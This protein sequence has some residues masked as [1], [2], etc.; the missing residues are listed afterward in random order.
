MKGAYSKFLCEIEVAKMEARLRQ[1][2]SSPLASN[3][4]S[5]AQSNRND[6]MK[7]DQCSDANHIIF[8]TMSRKH[9]RGAFEESEHPSVLETRP[10][11]VSRRSNT[12]PNSPS[13]SPSDISVR[14]ITMADSPYCKPVQHTEEKMDY[15]RS[16]AA[17]ES[18]SDA[19]E[20]DTIHG[21]E[22]ANIFEQVTRD[23]LNRRLFIL[24]N[25]EREK[26]GNPPL[27]WDDELFQ[28]AD[29]ASYK[30]SSGIPYNANPRWLAKLL[31]TH[32][33]PSLYFGGVKEISFTVSRAKNMSLMTMAKNILSEA[34]ANDDVRTE[35]FQSLKRVFVGISCRRSH[36]FLHITITVF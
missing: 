3:D 1:S 13:P 30:L 5:A 26:A 29:H 8:Q 6:F 12:S 14:E 35:V 31:K 16:T 28:M 20:K 17:M 7:D 9:N 18:W 33:N 27:Q 11:K 21:H 34:M 10:S 15:C 22:G 19:D 23:R 25:W 36:F 4:G 32:A 24:S 2:Q